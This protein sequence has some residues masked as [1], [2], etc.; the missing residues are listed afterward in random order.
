MVTTQ[1]W[2]GHSFGQIRQRSSDPARAETVK[3]TNA[4]DA[5]PS[6]PY[7]AKPQSQVRLLQMVA[8]ELQVVTALY[9]RS[10]CQASVCEKVFQLPHS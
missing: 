6:M 4:L 5:M 9:T 2:R 8:H 10:T 7:R 1:P 3:Q